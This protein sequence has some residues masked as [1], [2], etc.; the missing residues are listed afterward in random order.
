M[1]V[2]DAMIA[3]Q[4]AVANALEASDGVTD[5]ISGIYDYFTDQQPALPYIAFGPIEPR[6]ENLHV[7]GEQDG[8]RNVELT[9]TFWLFDDAPSKLP[10]LEA[11]KECELAL[12]DQVLTL[13]YGTTNCK[14]DVYIRRAELDENLG[15]WRTPVEIKQL[16]CNV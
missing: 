2:A 6:Y 12:A 14:P 5:K 7:S 15:L 4:E 10:S 8:T 9:L 13:S 3:L 16:V 11:L 1:T